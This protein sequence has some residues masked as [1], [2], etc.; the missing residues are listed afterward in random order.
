MATID[1]LAE[2]VYL[3]TNRPD[4]VAETAVAIRKAIRKV[5]GADTFKRDLKVQRLNM[6]TYPPI[7]PNQYRWNIALS[8]FE[9][10]RRPKSIGYPPDLQPPIHVPAPLIDWPAGYQRDRTFIELSV[11]NLY[12]SYG[13][14]K[15]NYYYIA[16]TDL[17]IKSGWYVDFL[18]IVYYQWPLIPSATGDTLTSWIVNTYPDAIVEEASSLVFKMIGKDDEYNR[19]AQMFAENLQI[20]RATDVGEGN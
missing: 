20:I 1:S 5:H 9:R 2:D 3:T 7:D 8:T 12:D 11:D 17:M 18:D 16:G 4:M 15:A 19:F 13:W 6:S 14:E 10:F